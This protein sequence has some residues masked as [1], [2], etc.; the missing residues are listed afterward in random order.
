MPGFLRGKGSGWVTAEY[1]MLPRATNTRT[2]LLYTS[3][4]FKR[5][6]GA[7]YRSNGNAKGGNLSATYA[8]ESF[9]M[10]YSGA[11]AESDN[12]AA[13]GDFKNYD[14]TGRMGHTLPRDEVGSTAYET[15][16]SYTHLDVYKRQR[17]V[18]SADFSGYRPAASADVWR[19]GADGVL[20]WVCA[21]ARSGR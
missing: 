19:A 2:C 3:S 10:T 1:G 4:L 18:V 12:Y 17:R 13:G 5:A 16:V 14:F 20:Q 11:T 21:V 8:T 7:F 15:P 6:A 9:S